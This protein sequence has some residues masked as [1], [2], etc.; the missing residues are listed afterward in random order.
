MTE[1]DIILADEPTGNFDSKSGRI[2]MEELVKINREYNKTIVMVTH[3]P[4]LASLCGRILFMKDGRFIDSIERG[5]SRND[6]YRQILHTM[7][8]L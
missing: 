3:D 2:V 1:P 7:S 5:E 6:F 4:G 8:V